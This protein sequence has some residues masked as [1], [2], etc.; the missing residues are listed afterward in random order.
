[1]SDATTNL[2]RKEQ[3]IRKAAELFKDKG[4]A[5]ASMRDLAQLLG[6]EAASLYSHIKSKEEILRSLCFDMAS[7]FRKSLDEVEKQKASASEKLRNGIIGHIQVMAK[8]LTASAVFMNEHRHLSQPY[9]R[10]FL[11]MR[12][13]YINRF[14]S[15]IEQGVQT[16]EFKDSIDKKLAVMTLFSSLNWMPM[17]YDPGSAIDPSQLGYQL[18]D[19]LINGLKKN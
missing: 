4:Y 2:S 6:I 5:A 18:A 17:W 9:L 11:L 3:V 15:I 12:I 14:K 19:M 8:D 1:M 13:N 7:E 16:G 10:D